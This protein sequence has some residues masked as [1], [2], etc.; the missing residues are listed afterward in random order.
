MKEN[1][2]VVENYQ[3]TQNMRERGKHGGG[4]GIR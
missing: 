4:Q 2:G 1:F 3:F